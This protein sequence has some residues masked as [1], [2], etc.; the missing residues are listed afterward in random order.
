MR[1]IFIEE[2]IAAAKKNKKIILIVNDLG[3]NV[4]EKFAKMFPSQFFN[5]GV[6]EQNMMGI[7]AGM[8]LEGYHVFVYSIGNFPTFRCSEQI[9]NDVDYHNL[10]VTIVNVGA[11]LSYGNLGYSHHSLQDYGLMRLFPNM[12]IAS[13][14]DEME[15]KACM[16]Y[17][18]KKPQPSY[19]RLSK[20]NTK[21]L[22]NKIP[23]LKP[24]KWLSIF[25]SNRIS[26]KI[27]LTTGNVASIAKK[28][29]T[30]KNFNNYSIYS[31]PLW[32][33][34]YK[35]AQFNQIKNW[36]KI[37]VLE[38]HLE[39]GGFG[40]WIKESINNNKIKTHI[41]S[42]S[43]SNKV[44]GKVGSEKYLLENYYLKLISK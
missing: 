30:N 32:G 43:L 31:L 10:P 22:H 24:G 28:F 33:M 29:L 8:A 26:K 42:K 44:I 21:P 34:K 20:S 6:A 18:L 13:P 25:K 15:T 38:D 40:S 9:R 4:V 11:G 12:L 17:I 16:K 35:K 1:K 39:D 41:I 19:L 14:G 7:A 36:D 2:L 23:N 27:F 37:V 5:A 3:Y